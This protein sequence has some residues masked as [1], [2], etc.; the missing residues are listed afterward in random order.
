M[1]WLDR[2][3]GVGARASARARARKARPV[4]EGLDA[5]EL[6]SGLGGAAP[7][8]RAA[9][10]TPRTTLRVYQAEVQPRLGRL[11]VTFLNADGPLDPAG[12]ARSVS[13]RMA[14]APRPAPLTLIGTPQVYPT[15]YLP[16]PGSPGGPAPAPGLQTVGAV[17]EFGRPLPRGNYIVR[18]DAADVTDAA[19]RT[20]DGEYRGRFP[21]GDGR[22]G[23]D[24]V[25]R[26]P[27]NGFFQYRPK[28]VAPR[29]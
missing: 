17:F 2:F 3:G 18:I 21:S 11:L 14:H 27:T 4:V 5:R 24:F 6:P 25:A 12:L 7:G 9:Q 20:L 15:D 29:G 13:L 23:G 28:V 22:P 16:L 8:I 19:G 26:F 1:G 10:P